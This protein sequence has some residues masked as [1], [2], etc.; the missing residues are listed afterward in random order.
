M[1]V[2]IGSDTLP[3]VLIPLL[4]LAKISDHIVKKRW[5]GD[6]TVVPLLVLHCRT[7]AVKLGLFLAR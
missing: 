7:L 5:T 6:W 2:G 3:T 4:D 1:T